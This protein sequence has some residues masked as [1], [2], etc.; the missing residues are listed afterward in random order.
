M[1]KIIVQS[2]CKTDFSAA[3]I[4]VKKSASRFFLLLMHVFL[5]VT[6]LVGGLLLMSVPDGSALGMQPGWLASSPFESYLLPGIILFLVLGC[7]CVIILAGLISEKQSPFINRI[8]LY[9]DRHWAWTYSL[10]Q[11]IIAI[12]WI[13]VQQVLTRY[14]WI[15]SV[16]IGVGL[17]IIVL[18]LL[19]ANIA[20]YTIAKNQR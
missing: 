2:S 17:L 18:T 7:G 16:I 19:P 3:L 10:Y 9:E 6:A 15:Q 5:A 14:F 4:K 1:I 12:V 13:M 11:G 20:Y 8:N